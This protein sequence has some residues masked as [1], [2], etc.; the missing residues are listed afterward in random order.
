LLQKLGESRRGG[1]SAIVRHQLH[2]RLAA[3]IRQMIANG[4]LQPGEKIPEKRLCEYFQVSRTPLREAIK[5]LAYEGFVTLHAN[6]SATVRVFTIS[7]IAEAFPILGAMESLAGELACE[8]MSSAD[9]GQLRRLHDELMLHYRQ[10]DLSAYF[11]VNKKIHETILTVARNAKLTGIYG[12]LAEQIRCPRAQGGLADDAWAQAIREHE[13]IVE[14]VEA[15]DG[16]RLGRVLRDH[17]ANKY[18]YLEGLNA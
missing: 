11:T 16:K 13:W 17:L 10:R 5:V 4:E 8:R 6:R 3:G 2:D 9:A 18:R 7:E 15:R 12:P 1:G 14:A